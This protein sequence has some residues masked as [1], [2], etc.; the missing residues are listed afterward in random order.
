MIAQDNNQGYPK[1]QLRGSG[2]GELP[3]RGQIPLSNG[4]QRA[5]EGLI[6]R[7]PTTVRSRDWD[8]PLVF[9]GA[10]THV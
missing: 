2:V 1:A 3:G 10:R 9:E 5:I 6:S 7:P 4:M 8:R